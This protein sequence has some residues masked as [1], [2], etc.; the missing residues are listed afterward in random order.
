[1][2]IFYLFYISAPINGNPTPGIP[3]KSYDAIICTHAFSLNQLP[4][5]A[6]DEF[7]RIVKSGGWLCFTTIKNFL[8][9][10]EC[11][12]LQKICNLVLGRKVDM[13]FSE[14]IQYNLSTSN[15]TVSGDGVNLGQIFVCKVL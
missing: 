15:T 13:I 2:A 3:A 8:I 9:Q 12:F 1:M 7:T 11:G 14:E 10:K 4:S 6:L 5:E